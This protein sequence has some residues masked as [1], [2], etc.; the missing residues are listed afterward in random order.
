VKLRLDGT[1][2]WRIVDVDLMIQRTPDPEGDVWHH[3]R[4]ALIQAVSRSTLS[5]FMVGFNGIVMN[6]FNA[7]AADGFYTERGVSVISM[8]LTRYEP[9]DASTR[10]V[11]QEIIQE[12]TNRINRLQQQESENEVAAARL[13]ADIELER[14]NTQLIQTQA[15]NERLLA[16]MEGEASGTRLAKD[17]DSFIRVLG[18][19]LPD[20][21]ARVELYRMHKTLTA[22]NENT[23][24][25]SQGS[26][27]LFLTPNDMN[28]RLHMGGDARRQLNESSTELPLSVGEIQGPAGA[29]DPMSSSR[30][31]TPQKMKVTRT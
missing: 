11:L 17:A 10:L 15:E 8:E 13:S 3:A 16:R 19:A 1:L 27:T 24:S 20:V 12:T 7:Q 29:E 25:L 14:Q 9:T 18:E 23:R 21:N 22:Q 2:F 5:Q 31:L 26:A 4:A 30:R 28:L 6:A